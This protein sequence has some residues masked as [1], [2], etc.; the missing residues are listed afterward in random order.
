MGRNCLWQQQH[1]TPTAQVLLLEEL[2]AEPDYSRKW[3]AM[4]AVGSG[5]LTSTIDGSIVN[6]ALNT[7]VNEFNSNLNIVTWVILGFLLTL[8]CLLLLMGRLGD[9]FGRRRIYI[10]GF[11]LFTIASV[12]CGLAWNIGSLIGFRVLQAA[13]A[14]MIQALG[15]ALLVTAFPPSER[16]TALGTIGSVVAVG[17]MSG[18]PLGG[19]I[20]EH[21]GW[22]AIF[23]VNIPVGIAGVWLSM[24]SLPVDQR[25]GRRPRFD[26]LGA[27]LLLISLSGFLLGLTF[28]PEQGWNSS[29]VIGPVIVGML[30]GLLFIWWELRA[31]EPM[32]KLSMFRKA[33]FSFNL[34]A[35]LLLFVGLAFNLILTPLILQLLFELDLQRTGLVLMSLPLAL[36]LT[37]PISGRLSD[38]FGPRILTVAGLS[39]VALGFFGHSR[40]GVDTPL[41]Q[42]IAN[43]LILGAGIGMFQSPNNSSVLGNAPPEALGV[44]S[45]V[46]AVM[47][48]LGQTSGVALASAIWS[49]QIIVIMGFPIDPV[50]SAPREVIA[51]AFDRA[52]LVAAG[53]A[54]LAI[55]P[56]ILGGRAVGQSHRVAAEAQAAGGKQ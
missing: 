38:R 53:L 30:A 29:M 56:S 35:G 12:L 28:A 16:G 43:L 44:A 34:L 18:P 10:F 32:L 40:T 14:A 55:I 49:A 54:L 21:I 51:A 42:F 37:S 15:P 25:D 48:T 39:L 5:V 20:I 41:P 24:S 27:G 9:M 47:R 3:W 26:F 2:L 4:A 36:S 33:A 13:G 1:P 19:F 6:I 46:L 7:L 52:T 22:R 31:P 50:T 11:V 17:I 8:T 23:L 45:G